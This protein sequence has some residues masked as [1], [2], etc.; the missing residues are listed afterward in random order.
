MLALAP[1]HPVRH[2]II[3]THFLDNFDIFLLDLKNQK[4]P[5]EA[6][7]VMEAVKKAYAKRVK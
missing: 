3:G 2:E 6:L 7:C 4:V 5:R 1:K